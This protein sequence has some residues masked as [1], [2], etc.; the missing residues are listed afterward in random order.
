[1]ELLINHE[2]PASSDAVHIVLGAAAV[3]R[4]RSSST[5][6]P[7]FNQVVTDSVIPKLLRQGHNQV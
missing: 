1:M 7:G 6:L 4:W 5:T 3:Q 2:M